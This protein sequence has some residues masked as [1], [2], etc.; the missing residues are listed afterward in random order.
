MIRN[1][2]TLA[3]LGLGGLVLA[4]GLAACA[5]PPAPPPRGAPAQ[6]AAGSGDP[7][8]GTSWTVTSYVGADGAAQQSVAGVET[9]IAFDAGRVSGTAGCNRLTGSYTVDG[10]SLAFGPLASTMMACP[11]PQ[12][13][14]EQAVFNAM[15]QTATYELAGDQLILKDAS[16]VTVLTLDK[17]QPPSLTGREWTA[18]AINNGEQAV[19]SVAE[20]STVTANFAEDGTMSGSGGCNTYSGRYTVDGDKIKIGPLAVTQRMCIE[21]EIMEQEQAF[22]NALTNA[23]RFMIELSRLDLFAADGARQ[24]TFATSQ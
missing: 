6:P 12:M 14:Q 22:F 11:E 2:S 7:L 1:T 4:L 8:S 9:L 10:P 5:L 23:E 13:A 15:G 18:L 3:R 17:A 24:V 20:G 19:V 21:N 16:G